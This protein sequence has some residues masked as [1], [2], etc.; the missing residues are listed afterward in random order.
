MDIT[1]PSS[2]YFTFF[3]TPS[4]FLFSKVT[5]FSRNN[6][7]IATNCL[8]QGYSALIEWRDIRAQVFLAVEQVNPGNGLHRSEHPVTLRAVGSQSSLTTHRPSPQTAK[9]HD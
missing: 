4:N 2:C 8:K 3:G 7:T 9:N 5:F 1:S 6:H